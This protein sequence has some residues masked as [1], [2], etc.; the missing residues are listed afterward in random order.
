M[1]DVTLATLIWGHQLKR[2]GGGESDPPAPLVAGLTLSSWRARNPCWRP[3]PPQEPPEQYTQ[4]FAHRR[5]CV[6]SLMI[7]RHFMHSIVNSPTPTRP[8]ND[9]PRR[10]ATRRKGSTALPWCLTS[11]YTRI[12]YGWRQKPV[13]C[14]LFHDFE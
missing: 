1:H 2:S 5:T 3:H 11:N 7:A 14:Y 9:A 12:S 4:R 6:P 13:Q 10:H 8:P